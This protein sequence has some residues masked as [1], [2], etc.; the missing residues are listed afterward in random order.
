MQQRPACC[1]NRVRP[2]LTGK[3]SGASI[4]TEGGAPCYCYSVPHWQRGAD[5]FSRSTLMRT[6]KAAK[7]QTRYRLT[8]GMEH[9]TNP[10]GRTPPAPPAAPALELEAQA[11]IDPRE[12]SPYVHY[13]GS[14]NVYHERPVY[15][16]TTH[17]EE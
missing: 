6:F 15:D 4:R 13:G 8:I 11:V 3:T 17:A 14:C 5:R 2:N 1:P 12:Y 7:P 16:S 9:R 10:R